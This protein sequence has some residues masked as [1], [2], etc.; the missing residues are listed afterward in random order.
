MG[1]SG[2]AG[3]LPGLISSLRGALLKAMSKTVVEPNRKVLDVQKIYKSKFVA[4]VSIRQKCMMRVVA[5]ANK[6]CTY[7]ILWFFK[8]SLCSNFRAGDPEEW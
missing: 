5:A 4:K 1:L 7:I 8:I 2:L 3:E 6:T